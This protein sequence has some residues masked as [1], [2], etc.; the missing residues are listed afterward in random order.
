MKRTLKLIL[1]ATAILVA[2]AANSKAAD[3]TWLLNANLSHSALE[4]CHKMYY[5]DKST[6]KN[7]FADT[8]LQTLG[9][10]K[11]NNAILKKEAAMQKDVLSGIENIEKKSILMEA[12]VKEIKKMPSTYDKDT[13]TEK[14]IVEMGNLIVNYHYFYLQASKEA[15]GKNAKLPKNSSRADSLELLKADKATN[16]LFMKQYIKN[17]NDLN[18]EIREIQKMLAMGGLI[19]EEKEELKSELELLQNE[20]YKSDRLL[21]ITVEKLNN[22]REKIVEVI[23][24]QSSLKEEFQKFDMDKNGKITIEE[25]YSTIDRFLEGKESI[26]GETVTALIDFYLDAD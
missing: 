24:E 23:F 1:A 4:Y 10:I 15:P 9:L 17:N 20:K 22:T 3:S 14:L 25:V 16:F 11:T 5:A 6:Q 18:F 12:M 26:S 7:I 19:K 13:G 21:A 2:T 8:L